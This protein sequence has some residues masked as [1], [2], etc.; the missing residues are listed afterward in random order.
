MRWRTVCRMFAV[1]F[2]TQQQ[3]N[4]KSPPVCLHVSRTC[5]LCSATDTLGSRLHY[6]QDHEAHPLPDLWCH[7]SPPGEAPQSLCRM[8]CSS[9]TPRR[10]L[11]SP[12]WFC[13]REGGG[14]GGEGEGEKRRREEEK[15]EKWGKDRLE[16]GKPRG[17]RKEQYSTFPQ[18]HV[19]LS[20]YI[21]FSHSEGCSF[22]F[23]TM[24]SLHISSGCH[25]NL[26][27][28]VIGAAHIR[29]EWLNWY[30]LYSASMIKAQLNLSIHH[31]IRHLQYREK[32]SWMLP[33]KWTVE[34]LST[35]LVS[36]VSEQPWDMMMNLS[37]AISQLL[38]CNVDNALFIFTSIPFKPWW[39]WET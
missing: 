9:H 31:D 5:G 26:Y 19:Q 11:F 3:E 14:G 4:N 22:A 23:K 28:Y 8:F 25:T 10:Q 38:G 33:A 36:L 16:T 13:W 24:E 6:S 34:S 35:L 39:L 2:R 15:A 12:W 20:G 32:Q 30:T 7:C 18:I 29:L 27:C 21:I 1:I 17:N 37:N